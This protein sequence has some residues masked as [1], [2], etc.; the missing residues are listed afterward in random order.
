MSFNHT[1]IIPTST[2]CSIIY[3]VTAN[4]CPNNKTTV[5]LYGLY[6]TAAAIFFIGMIWSAI[7]VYP[8]VARYCSNYR[9]FSNAQ[10]QRED[11]EALLNMQHII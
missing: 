5:A 1:N 4:I 6:F 10:A 11:D 8:R 9:F 3:G 7:H 2:P